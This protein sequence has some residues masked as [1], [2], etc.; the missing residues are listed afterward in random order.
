ML[1]WVKHDGAY[2]FT[3]R[4]PTGLA[5]LH[6]GDA[7]PLDMFA[8]AGQQGALAGTFATFEADEF[9]TRTHRQRFRW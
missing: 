8:Q 7:V 3:Q 5:R 4:R 1:G 6:Q 2:R 9:S